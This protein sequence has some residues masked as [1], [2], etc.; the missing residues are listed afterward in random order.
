MLPAVRSC[1]CFILLPP[2]KVNP[3]LVALPKN[4]SKL[5]KERDLLIVVKFSEK[6]RR[7]DAVS[8]LREANTRIQDLEI[9][10]Q[11]SNHNHSE[12]HHITKAQFTVWGKALRT[13]R[14]GLK[15]VGRKLKT[16]ERERDRAK[17]DL[18]MSHLAKIR[19]DQEKGEKVK[20]LREVKAELTKNK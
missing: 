10:L 16:V 6:V 17:G 15:A 7:G 3:F 4:P 13:A 9:K 11:A 2:S 18:S 14:T 19:S 5:S 12:C 1:P 20:A 8:K